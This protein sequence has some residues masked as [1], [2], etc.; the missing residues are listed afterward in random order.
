[1]FV[2]P[3]RVKSNT[4]I[5]GSD[6]RKLKAD[7]GASFPSLSAEQLSELIPNKEELNVLKIYTHKGDAVTVYVT[8]KNP[9][10]FE[11]EKKLYPTVYTLW[12]CSDLLPALTTWPAVLQKLA[13]G[14]DLMLPGVV[15]P[16]TGLP[17]VQRGSLCAVTLVGNGA[18]VGVGIAT[19]SSE[20]MLG[21]GMKGKGLTLTHT[22]LD[23]LW[24]FGDKS[25]PP[26]VAPLV[27]EPAE[28]VDSSEEK[29]DSP[30]DAINNQDFN[31]PP[32]L[33][34]LQISGGH[35]DFTEGKE[36]SE[37]A[38][39]VAAENGEEATME[40][41]E[42]EE[43]APQEDMDQLLLQCFLHAVKYKVKKS[44]LPLLTSTFL[45]NHMYSCRPEGKQLDIKKSSYKK[46]SKFLQ[47]M[48]QRKIIL[49]KELSKGVESIVDVEWKHED[50][51]SFKVPEISS[52]ADSTEIRN[53][54]DEDKPYLP[55]EILPLYSVSAK[56]VPLFQESRHK[57]GDILS[58]SEVRSIITNYVKS[59]ELVNETNKNFVTINPI[60]CDCVLDKSEHS[61][62]TS[63]KWDDLFASLFGM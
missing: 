30:V 21:A 63:L 18:P 36:P 25:N 9:V 39:T 47:C 17:Q 26:M 22:Y 46:L 6:R 15:M 42:A 24:G 44:D 3:F 27:P 23:L 62:I 49:V 32:E 1:M 43:K 10:F 51:R 56:L 45:R 57:K 7:I 35:S 4:S 38:D 14:A 16:P 11:V 33:E 8:H 50:I 52:S 55:P 2:K 37:S 60:L 41:L 34:N 20:E 13:G 31:P 58:S 53:T 19:M 54:G 28:M 29:E 48:Q 59:N 61:E 5:K 12:S 40:Q